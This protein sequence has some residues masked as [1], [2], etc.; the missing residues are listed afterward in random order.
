M[1]S[2]FLV[3][4]LSRIALAA[5][6]TQVVVPAWLGVKAAA[7]S[8]ST[9]ELRCIR[10]IMPFSITGASHLNFNVTTGAG[11]CAMGLFPDD[12][13]GSVLLSNSQSCTATGVKV[14]T[15]SPTVNLDAGTT[16][17]LCMCSSSTSTLVLAQES[18]ASLKINLIANATTVKE[19][20]AANACTTGALPPTTGA[21][22]AASFNLPFGVIE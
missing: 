9:D 18:F 5:S 3:L 20:T 14:G 1:R 6:A 11:T 21:L 19:G 17:R 22:T 13:A 15:T 10:F 16:Y 2:L 12:N 8:S 7:M 4:V